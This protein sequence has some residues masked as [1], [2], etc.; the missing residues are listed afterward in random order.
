MPNATNLSLK[1]APPFDFAATAY[2]H[3]W[4]V[5]LPNSWDEEARTVRSVHRLASGQVVSLE[6]SGQG[7]VQAPEI[8]VKVNHAGKL[9]EGARSELR[10]VV[11]RMLRLDEYLSA[12]YTLCRRR[13][14]NWTKLTR[15]LG[16][17][18]RSPTVFEDLV[19]TICTTNI[20]WGG[21]MRMAAALVA[22]YGEP[23]DGD[24]EMRAFPTPEAIAAASLS[25]FAEAVRMGYRAPY[26]HELAQR[27]AAGD[28]DPENFFDASIPTPD[29][30]KQLLAIKGVGAYAASTMLMLLGRY[31]ELA[32]DTVFRQFVSQKYFKGEKMTDEEAKAI[33]ED[34][35]EW[36]YLAYWFDI[37]E[38][39][40]EPL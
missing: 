9:S 30:K 38:G 4:V 15:G 25:D 11:G 6:I 21:T 32:V 16:R 24:G 29:L 12:F 39:L 5:L 33:Y 34:W 10:A 1:P 14:G 19:K 28:L 26:V 22:S 7:N 3:G 13:G 18:F 2:S 20:Q 35:G 40:N 27:V 36:K 37:W 8:I 23:Y 17:L 31:D